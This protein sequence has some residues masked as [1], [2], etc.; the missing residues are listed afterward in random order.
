MKY[1]PINPELFIK[2]RERFA[3]NMRAKS[4]AVF[5]SNDEMPRNGDQNYPFRQNSDL[6]YLSGIDQ[7]QSIL[8]IFP[9]CPIERYREILFVRETNEQIATWEGF[10]LT[11]KE[12]TDIS[13]I[14]TILWLDSF[15]A[16]FNELAA[17]ARNIYLNSNENIRYVNEIDY[18][19][20]RFAKHIR[21]KYPTHRIRRSARIMANL[22]TVKSDIEIDLIKKAIDITKKSFL[23]LLGFVK[24][25]VMEFEAEAEIQHEFL[26]NRANANSFHSIVASGKN[27]CSLHYNANNCE[28][29]DGDLVLFDIGAEYANYAADLSRT[30]PING[31]Y[32]DRQKDCYNAVLRV[33]KQAKS[34]LVVGTTIDKYHEA[35]CKLMEK[36]MIGLGLFTEEDVK[37]QNQEAPLLKKY[38]PH[39][40]SHFMGLDVH[41][42][43]FKQEP[44]KAGMV[45][46]CEPGIYIPEE[47]IGIRIE[48]VI[49]VTEGGPIDLTEQI[50]VEID[51]IEALMKK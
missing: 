50:P 38:Y 44:L 22:R 24:P 39:G 30:I 42:L 37:K 29:K 16:V 49:L 12:A 21:D 27:A 17:N 3:Q 32:T 19:D 1:L 41:D 2:N 23:R 13:G 47:G 4:L 6:F 9:D 28:C 7:E 20:L 51:E 5:H 26:R 35:V 46:S 18:K 31:K 34:M 25:G 8:V 43:G 33:M 11:K 45:F 48:N 14:K 40:T 36:E 10:K 15:D